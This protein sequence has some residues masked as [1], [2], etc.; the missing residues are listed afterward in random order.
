[1]AVDRLTGNCLVWGDCKEQVIITPKETNFQSLHD[2]FVIHTK[3]K[4]TYK[5]MYLNDTPKVNPIIECLS[6]AFNNKDSS[7]FRSESSICSTFISCNQ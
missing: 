5:L 6:R 3:L 1:M 2:I 4:V 7:D